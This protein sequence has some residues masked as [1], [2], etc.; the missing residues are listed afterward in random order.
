MEQMNFH[1]QK[2]YSLIAAGVALISLILPWMVVDFGGFGGGSV[3]GFRGW[4]ILSLFGVLGVVAACFMGDKSI[5]FDETSKKIALGSFAAIAVGALLFFL[6][7]NSK[8]GGLLKPGLGLWLG[9]IAGLAG[10][11]WVMGFIKLPDSKKPPTPP[12]PP[13]P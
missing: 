6:R 13:M 11:A 4:G 1:K 12:T 7:L 8:G 5:Q 3:N 9:L 10:V 2:L